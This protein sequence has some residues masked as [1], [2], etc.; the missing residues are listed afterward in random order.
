[1][2]ILQDNFRPKVSILQDKKCQKVSILQ[3]STPPRKS[4]IQKFGPP[5]TPPSSPSIRL[6]HKAQKHKT[7]KHK[8]QRLNQDSRLKTLKLKPFTSTQYQGHKAK[9]YWHQLY[10]YAER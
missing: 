9:R 3:D 2:S 8:A 10:Q 7:L 6:K 5:G 1:M 4:N